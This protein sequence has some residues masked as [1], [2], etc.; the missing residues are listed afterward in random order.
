MLWWRAPGVPSWAPW[1][2]LALQVGLVA[3]TAVWWG[4]L[5]ARL[6]KPGGG[7]ALDRFHLLMKTHWLR[8]AITTAYGGLTLWMIAQ[9]AWLAGST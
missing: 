1:A 4:P 6:E 9:S 7:L 3:G 5:M 8:V 2:G